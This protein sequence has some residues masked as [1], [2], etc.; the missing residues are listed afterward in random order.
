MEK[1]VPNNIEPISKINGFMKEILKE[2]TKSNELQVEAT[3][4]KIQNKTRDIYCPLANIWQYLGALNTAKDE[5]A[6]ADK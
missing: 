5:T 1:P 2:R 4:E 6:Y 3:I